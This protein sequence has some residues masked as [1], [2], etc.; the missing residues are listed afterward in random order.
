MR[1]TNNI[2]QRNAAFTLQQNLQA[3]AKAQ[4]QVSTGQRFTQFSDDPQAQ[5]SVMQTSS[6]L[7]ALEQYQRNIGDSTARANMEDTVLQQ[8]TD[9]VDR[10]RDIALQ[11]GTTT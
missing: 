11:E 2:I 1:V 8:L 7:R 9:A 6:S 3:M 4:N 10:G 5:S